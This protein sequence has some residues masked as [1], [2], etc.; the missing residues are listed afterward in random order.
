[1]YTTLRSPR[2]TQWPVCGAAL[3]SEGT[4][5][6]WNDFHWSRNGS[7]SKSWW[8]NEKWPV[9]FPG[10]DCKSKLGCKIWTKCVF[11]FWYKCSFYV[12]WIQ[13][14]KY[15]GDISAPSCS[16]WYGVFY[17]AAHWPWLNMVCLQYIREF[18]A[19]LW[20]AWLWAQTAL[21]TVW[22]LCVCLVLDLYCLSV[23]G[24]W[25]RRRGFNLTSGD[26]DRIDKKLRFLKKRQDT[27]DFTGIRKSFW[28]DKYKK[29]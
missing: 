23:V 6:N 20:F 11:S 16:L 25:F 7:H 9:M 22:A 26:E 29:V 1:M 13:T 18:W 3:L 14:W 2:L 24:G 12:L 21:R 8:N 27:S 19:C 28:I 4:G 5:L 10:Y 17:L 15:C